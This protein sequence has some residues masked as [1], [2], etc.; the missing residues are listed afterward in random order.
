MPSEE[1]QLLK[2]LGRIEKSLGASRSSHNDHANGDAKDEV[3]KDRGWL[4]YIATEAF[5]LA[6]PIL[7]STFGRIAPAVG[8][9][10]KDAAAAASATTADPAYDEGANA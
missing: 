9:D 7:V 6:R 1:D 10:Q 3:K 2:R 8:G 5:K 4:T